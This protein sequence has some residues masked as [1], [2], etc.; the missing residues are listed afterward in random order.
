MT[1]DGVHRGPWRRSADARRRQR[2]GR[3]SRAGGQPDQPWS[4]ASRS[5][6][7]GFEDACAASMPRRWP[8]RTPLAAASSSWRT[9]MRRRMRP[10]ETPGGCPTTRRRRQPSRAA[11]TREAARG[12]AA[13]PLAVVEAC[14]HQV[15]L[16]ERLAG[17]TLTRGRQRPRR[18]RPP[19]REPPRGERPRTSWSTCR[20]SRTRPTR[21][22]SRPSST[23]GCGTIAGRCGADTGAHR[24]WRPHAS[25]A[26]MSDG[27]EGSGA[28]CSMG[29][30]WR[31]QMLAE[32]TRRDRR[33]HDGARLDPGGARASSS[34][35]IPPRPSTRGASCA[36]AADGRVAGATSSARR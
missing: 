25:R 11:A 9:R 28:E 23:S 21:Q 10:I 13:V 35:T 22:P 17:R 7:P 16:V 26:R 32:T 12:A 30:P 3:G 31:W 29:G 24:G 14:H 5:V 34:G 2:R 20:P 6:V 15:D 36:T 27:G 19:A 1:I 33:P 18:G 8:L 4:S